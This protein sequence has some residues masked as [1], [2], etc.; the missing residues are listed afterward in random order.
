MIIQHEHKASVKQH[1]KRI[2]VRL[3]KEELLQ[4]Q[5]KLQKEKLLHRLNR[6]PLLLE[7]SPFNFPQLPNDLQ[8]KI[9]ARISPRCRNQLQKTCQSL[10]AKGSKQLPHI[11]KLIDY[12]LT[13]AE[14]DLSDIVLQ[15]IVYEKKDAL[16]KIL[17]NHKKR[18][19]IYEYTDSFDQINYSFSNRYTNYKTIEHKLCFDAYQAAPTKIIY[20]TLKKYGC[21]TL[22][23]N[24]NKTE[25]KLTPLTVACFMQDEKMLLNVIFSRSNLSENEILIALEH[26][27]KINNPKI[28]DVLITAFPIAHT[29]YQKNFMILQQENTIKTLRKMNHELKKINDSLQQ[30]LTNTQ[31]QLTYTKNDLD[32]LEHR[33]RMDSY[34]PRSSYN[35]PTYNTYCPYPRLF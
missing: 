19:F 28:N 13:I 7:N 17:Q 23:E 6:R 34:Y 11:W 8:L 9:I 15:A 32:N 18:N 25:V 5:A 35:I 30:E 33:N 20:D 21:N 29:I 1:I 27:Q 3:H 31:R 14:K 10:Q 24:S 4:T 16:E 26:N 22:E 2:Q 12:P